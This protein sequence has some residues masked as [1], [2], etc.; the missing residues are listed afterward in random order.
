MDK[1]FEEQ[2]RNLRT[3]LSNAGYHSFQIDNIIRDIAGT[4]DLVALDSTMQ[5]EL[6]G[7][8]ENHI[9]FAKKCRSSKK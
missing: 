1:Q 9:R 7:E 3:Q 8:L 6:L 2:L 5:A 4:N